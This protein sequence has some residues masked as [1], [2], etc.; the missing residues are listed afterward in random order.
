MAD[1]RA[2]IE[3]CREFGGSFHWGTHTKNPRHRPQAAWHI[4]SQG[5]LRFL[6]AVRD[7]LI[8]KREEAEIGIEFQLGVEHGRNSATEVER[9]EQ[10]RQQILRAK[11]RVFDPADFGMVAKSGDTQN[12]QSRAKQEGAS[13][14]GVCNESMPPATAERD[15]ELRGNTESAA[16]MIAPLG[17]TGSRAFAFVPTQ[18]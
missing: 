4:S 16:E 2:L 18:G 12:G 8:V 9:R 5:A 14:P 17:L 6:L 13:L 10:L 15:S 11:H 3:I 7:H 1:P